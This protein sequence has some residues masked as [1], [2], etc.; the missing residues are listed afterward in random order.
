LVEVRHEFIPEFIQE[1]I[2]N[3]KE[4]IKETGNLRFDILQDSDKPER[5]TLYE[6]YKT[7]E[8]SVAHKQ[9]PHYLKWRTNVEHMM[10]RPRIGVKHNVIAPANIE[11]W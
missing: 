9:T 8:S 3:H 6:A 7:E 4:S 1:C 10:A 5:F 11:T 2:M